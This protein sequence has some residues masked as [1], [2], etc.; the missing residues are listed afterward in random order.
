MGIPPCRQRGGEGAE[1]GREEDSRAGRPDSS[2]M[3]S[4]KRRVGGKEKREPCEMGERCLRA[5][6]V[7]QTSMCGVCSSALQVCASVIPVSLHM[8]PFTASSVFRFYCLYLASFSVEH[9]EY[10]PTEIRLNEDTIL[11]PA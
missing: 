2:A 4:A 7:T 5:Y 10:C 3:G 11:L 1:P 6:V 8:L 9:C